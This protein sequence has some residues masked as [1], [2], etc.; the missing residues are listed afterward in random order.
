MATHISILAWKIPWTE[1]SCGLRSMG[2]Q[3]ADMTEELSMHACTAANKITISKRY[4][5]LHIP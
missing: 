4:T 5:N 2:L 3:R 1:E